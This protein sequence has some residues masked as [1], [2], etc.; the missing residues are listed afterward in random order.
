MVQLI[1]Y[2]Q[3][4]FI[5]MPI[6]LTV[7]CHSSAQELCADIF[8]RT[9]ESKGSIR[10]LSATKLIA[11]KSELVRASLL[12]LLASIDI[13]K[14]EST[15]ISQFWAQLSLLEVEPAQVLKISALPI[16]SP[17]QEIQF[18][19]QVGTS[20]PKY[21]HFTVPARE[22]KRKS[23]ALISQLI[24]MYPKRKLLKKFFSGGQPAEFNSSE[25]LAIESYKQFGYIDVNSYLRSGHSSKDLQPVLEI[26]D[27]LDSAIKRAKN[28]PVG[29]ILFRG[30]KASP[31]LW[32]SP[33]ESFTEFQYIS[34]TTSQATAE[35]HMQKQSSLQ[36][37]RSIWKQI[38]QVILIQSDGIKGLALTGA[39]NEVLL[40]R[41]MKFRVFQIIEESKFTVQILEALP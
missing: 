22:R 29:T 16:G 35:H 23:A 20:S 11:E 34:T 39:E 6:I 9:D 19:V 4:K 1:R 5:L 38:L 41:G 31:D 8:S 18:S 12:P 40:S 25:K 21:V 27:G 3:L 2:D 17:M 7:G 32:R 24:S 28:V 10:Q 26:I 14:T 36:N 30:A 13:A 37:E 15:L 33:G